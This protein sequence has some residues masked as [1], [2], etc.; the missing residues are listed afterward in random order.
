[1]LK[2]E[3]FLDVEINHLL[4]GDLRTAKKLVCVVQVY[5]ETVH[6]EVVTM[7]GVFKYSHLACAVRKYNEV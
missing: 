4:A 1:M 3:D 2:I 5:R 7:D 6:Y